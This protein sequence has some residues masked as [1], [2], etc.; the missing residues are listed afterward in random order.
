[1][2]AK[3]ISEIK[4]VAV[5]FVI[6]C[7]IIGPIIHWLRV[8]PYEFYIEIYVLIYVGMIIIF[9]LGLRLLIDFFWRRI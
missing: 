9:G 8:G 3:E 1:M 7:F 5:Q 6:I 2:N 4:K